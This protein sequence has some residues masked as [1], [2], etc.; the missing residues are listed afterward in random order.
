MAEACL[1]LAVKSEEQI[2]K[3]EHI[4]KA[5][6]TC[7]NRGNPKVPMIDVNSKVNHCSA[8]KSV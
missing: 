1:F 5:T 4:I 7:V 3:M 2:R 8:C 6:H